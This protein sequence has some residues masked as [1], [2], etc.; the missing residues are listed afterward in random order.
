MNVIFA[1]T[2]EFAAAALSAL[3]VSRH[4]VLAVLTQPD[5]PSGRGMK[6]MA[7]PV[8][9][10][11]LALGLPVVQPRSLK[12]TATQQVLGEYRAD[13]LIVAAYGL[14][15]PQAVLDI[16]RLGA[17][18]IHASLLPRWRGAA[19]I[20]RAILA[21]DRETGICIMRMDAGLD[22]GPVLLEERLEIAD[23]DTAGTLHDKL[24]SVGGRLVVAALDGLDVGRLEPKPQPR[25]GAIYARKLEKTEARINW[26]MPA[27]QIWR[28]IRAFDPSPGASTELHRD[29][30]K[31]FG[32]RLELNASGQPGEVLAVDDDGVVI[33]CGSG[34]VKVVE[35]QRAGGRRLPFA[36][37]LRGVDAS[38]GARFGR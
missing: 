34:A 26:S 33:A 24:S 31:M 19:P 23:V 7:S 13:V 35:F 30:V 8:K 22:T 5:R 25:E 10:L 9:S 29:Q 14:I 11:A 6:L 18:N 28:L 37:F 12:D 32:A 36:E 15:L 21:G 3:S 4:S 2:P 38:V 1:G 20:Q 16:P 17:I 27:E